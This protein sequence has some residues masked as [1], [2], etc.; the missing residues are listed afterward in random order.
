MLSPPAPALFQGTRSAHVAP[1]ASKLF[2]VLLCQPALQGCERVELVLCFTASV[3]SIASGTF[4]SSVL[5][6][7]SHAVS[8]SCSAQS[9]CSTSEVH[10]KQLERICFGYCFMGQHGLDGLAS[11]CLRCDW[12]AS[13]LFVALQV[14][15][16]LAVTLCKKPYC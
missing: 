7:N 13:A 3:A 9:I 5:A 6:F 14:P 1:M 12:C 10:A 16:P 2:S 11:C 4:R 15:D 8:S